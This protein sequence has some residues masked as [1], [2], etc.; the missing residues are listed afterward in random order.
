MHARREVFFLDTPKGRRFCLLTRSPCRPVG[1]LLYLHPFAE[2][3]NKSRRMVALAASAFAAAGWAVLQMDLFG[4]GDSEG[5]FG[6]ADWQDWLDDVSFARGWLR[7]HCDGPLALWSLRAGAL[8]AADW[9]SS[10]SEHLPLLMWQPVTSGKQHLTQFLRLKAANEMLAESDARAAMDY[11]R[12]QLQAGRSVEIAGYRVSA[13]LAQGLGASRL[14]FPSK[15]AAPVALLEVTSS[16]QMALSPALSS[17]AKE[18]R[19]AGTI[20]SDQAVR[21]PAFWQTQEIEIAPQL[22]PASTHLLKKF[23]S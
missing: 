19:V 14:Q 13:G 8:V 1:G 6:D 2:E 22:I 21:G 15:Y 16:E 17:L 11:S 7:S 4:C 10:G 5:D 12:A 23:V 3:M 18:C 9:L 20:L